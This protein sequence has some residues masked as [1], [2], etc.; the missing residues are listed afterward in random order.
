[1]KN[2]IFITG[3]SGIGKTTIAKYISKEHGIPYISTSASNLWPTFGFNSHQEA[4]IRTSNDKNLGMRYQ[5]AIMEERAMA[6]TNGTWVTD[7]SPM[8][9]IAYFLLT[10]GHAITEKEARDFIHTASKMLSTCD[11][12]IHL[13]SCN[14]GPIEDNRKRILNPYY[15]MMVDSI[16]SMVIDNTCSNIPILELTTWDLDLRKQLTDTWLNQLQ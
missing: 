12:I 15:Q 9:N 14:Q 10:M 5:Y 1:M 13:K 6:L 16:I 7:R 3:P 2:K 8:D 4:H 11:G